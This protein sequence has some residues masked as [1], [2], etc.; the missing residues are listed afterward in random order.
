[1]TPW[2][3]AAAPGFEFPRESWL[4]APAAQAAECWVTPRT[5]GALAMAIEV[6]MPQVAVPA[7]AGP[8]PNGEWMPAP[9]AQAAGCWIG[10]RTADAPATAA[11]PRTPHMS[12][13]IAEAQKRAEFTPPAACDEWMPSPAAQAAECWIAARTADAFAAVAL[14]L[15]RMSALT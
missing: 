15:P 6:H 3:V 9:A 4:A 1:Q 7:I 14:L 12:L 11:E 5:A 8:A 10:A 13:T 2:I